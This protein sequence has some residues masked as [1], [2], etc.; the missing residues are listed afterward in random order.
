MYHKVPQALA[1]KPRNFRPLQ[2]KACGT[3]TFSFVY[4]LTHTGRF[5][6]LK[7]YYFLDSIY[8]TLKIFGRVA[9]IVLEILDEMRLVKEMVF[10][11]DIGQ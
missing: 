11:A 9:G 3:L 5:C 2:A 1:C 4:N 7:S 6:V 10:V 8:G